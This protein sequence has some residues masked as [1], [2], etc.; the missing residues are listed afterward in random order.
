MQRHYSDGGTRITRIKS[1]QCRGRPINVM[2]N[3]NYLSG[4]N[5]ATT[6]VGARRKITA[7]ETGHG[8][9]ELSRRIIRVYSRAFG[10]S[11]GERGFGRQ[12]GFVV[13]RRRSFGDG[14][15]RA[16]RPNVDR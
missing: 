2:R 3:V 10:Y 16:S 12:N 14:P 13:Y 1:G 11:K 15:P 7:E 8:Q 6:F 4:G 9:V 5:N